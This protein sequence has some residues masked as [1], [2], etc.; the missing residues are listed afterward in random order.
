MIQPKTSLEHSCVEDWYDRARRGSGLESRRARCP[1]F[2]LFR[3][4]AGDSLLKNARELRFS[5]R[6]GDAAPL[7]CAAKNVAGGR[8]APGNEIVVTST[9]QKPGNLDLN[10]Y[11]QF[12]RLWDSTLRRRPAFS[13]ADLSRALAD[14]TVSGAQV[15]V[16]A[17]LT[18]RNSNLQIPWFEPSLSRAVTC[19]S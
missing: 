8:T 13:P 14:L 2:R 3:V 15:T 12:D 4:G 1:P 5:H 6:T 18:F 10:D 17:K 16:R 11:T 9:P 7:P 19:L